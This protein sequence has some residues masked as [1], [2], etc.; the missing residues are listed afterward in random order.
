MSKNANPGT[1]AASLK[2]ALELHQ[3]GHAAEALDLLHTVVKRYPNAAQAHLILGQLQAASGAAETAVQSYDRALSLQPDYPEAHYSRGNALQELKRHADAVAS[4]DAVLKRVPNRP[5]VLANRGNALHDL[6]R[7]EAALS[8][9]DQALAL[10]P[11]VA[12]LHNNRGNTLRDLKRY[13]EALASL[14]KALALEPGYADALINRGNVLQDLGRYEEALAAF[15]NVLARQPEHLA[16]LNNRGNVLRDLRRH[17]EA[18]DTVAQLLALAPDWDYAIGVM[19]QS[20]LYSCDWTHFAQDAERVIRGVR[21][22]KKADIPF[23]FL[24]FSESAA[25]QWRCAQTYVA[26]KYPPSIMPLWTGERYRHDRIRVAYLSGDFHNHATAHL[27]AGLF[28]SHDT[29]RFETTAISFGPDVEDDMRVRLRK[30]FGQFMDVRHLRDHDVAALMRAMEID[31]AVDLKGF[32][33]DSRAGILAH[34][35]SPIQVNYLGYPG[36][37]GASYIDYILADRHVI[38]EAQHAYYTEKVV[39]LPDTYQVN[40][41]MRVIAPHTPTR[42][43][44]GL[45]P[46]GFVFCCFNNNY[47]ITPSIFDIWMRLLQQTAGSVL[48]LLEDNVMATRNLRA[49]A[50]RRGIAPQRLIFAP[51]LTLDAHLARHRLA[52]IF[53]DTLPYNAHTTASDALWAGLPVLACAGNA[54]AGRVTTSLLNAVGLPELIT[55]DVDAYEALALKLASTPAMLAGLRE[56]LLQNRATYPLFNTGRFRRHIEA[57]YL[58]M[59]ER[60]QRGEVPA[61]FAVAPVP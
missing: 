3:A 2:R 38:P 1:V 28:E 54:F 61:S 7:Y 27:M 8:S 51:R 19:F 24:A 21:A 46:E 23:S 40:D 32:T 26:D 34:R 42:A 49:E 44:C 13:A 43:E 30:A 47:K 14:D 22:G 9:Y 6:K 17:D 10:M 50:V 37:M 55:Y 60:Y 18:A 11:D 57:A 4:Y 12:M 35:P 33:V 5:E 41:A 48:W 53:L 52:D 56:K 16:A 58:S 29:A 31:I 59:W 25:D 36:T 15:D 20:R 45:P 39:V